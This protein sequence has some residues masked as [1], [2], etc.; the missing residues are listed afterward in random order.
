MKTIYMT[1]AT[2][3]LLSMALAFPVAAGGYGGTMG[4]KMG[5]ETATGMESP[6]SFQK[7]D[8]NH[9]GFLSQGEFN[10]FM[11]SD[12]S[13]VT[14]AKCRELGLYQGYKG[15]GGKSMGS[16]D[17][18]VRE[19]EKL[20]NPER[21]TKLDSNSDKYLSRS[22]VKKDADIEKRFNRIDTNGDDVLS[23][24]EF[25][26]FEEWPMESGDKPTSTK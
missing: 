25:A 5:M 9:D 2:G 21:F 11:Q 17:E 6:T 23:L 19:E 3:F 12:E 18:L 13:I 22:E 1:A 26:A 20:D 10:A 15:V 24:D 16:Y 14:E 4:K 8:K 7:F